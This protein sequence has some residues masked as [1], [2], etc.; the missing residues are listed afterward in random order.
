MSDHCEI[1]LLLMNSCV[2]R[3]VNWTEIV[4]NLNEHVTLTRAQGFCNVR[5]NPQGNLLVVTIA[6][7]SFRN[8]ARFFEQFLANR[9]R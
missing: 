7:Q 2:A 9:L 5:I 4:F 1:K 3:D 6:V 8:S